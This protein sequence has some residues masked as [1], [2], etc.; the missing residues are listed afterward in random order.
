MQ[1]KLKIVKIMYNTKELIIET[2]NLEFGFKEKEQVLK[3]ISLKVEKGSVYGFLGP[4]GAG[5]T[6]TTIQSCIY[7]SLKM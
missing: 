7:P 6:T 3:K 1:S 5:K 4:N 2:Q